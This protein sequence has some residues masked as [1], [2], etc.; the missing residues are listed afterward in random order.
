[1]TKSK[2]NPSPRQEQKD[3][4]TR[5]RWLL[6][7]GLIGIVILIIG[8]LIAIING[9][10]QEP[11]SPQVTGRPNAEVDQTLLDYGNV[12]F[13]TPVEA[14]F[15]VKNTGDKPLYILGEPR[16]ELLQGC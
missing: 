4:S 2:Q 15:H 16:V 8:A 14:V 12:Q 6:F 10:Q 5:P 9:R 7:A 1:M 11:Y 3:T 13:E